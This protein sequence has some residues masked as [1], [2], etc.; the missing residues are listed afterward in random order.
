MVVSLSMRVFFFLPL[1]LTDVV[2]SSSSPM[3]ACSL[4]GFSGFLHQ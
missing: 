1:A 4:P 3:V 2:Y